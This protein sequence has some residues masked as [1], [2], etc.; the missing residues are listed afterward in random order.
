MINF[1]TPTFQ[2]QKKIFFQSQNKNQKAPKETL[3]EKPNIL[4]ITTDA[5]GPP[6]TGRGSIWN[7]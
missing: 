3:D 2:R 1:L 6:D 7:K 5:N 4:V